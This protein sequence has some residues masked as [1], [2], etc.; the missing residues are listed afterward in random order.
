MNELFVES[1]AFE[2]EGLIPKQNTGHGAD[3]SPELLLNR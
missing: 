2:H 3:I 1:P